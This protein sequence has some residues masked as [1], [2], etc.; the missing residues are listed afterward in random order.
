VEGEKRASPTVWQTNLSSIYFWQNKKKLAFNSLANYLGKNKNLAKLTSPCEKIRALIR[1]G[2]SVAKPGGKVKKIK[3]REFLIQVFKR[4]K[5]INI[6]C[7]SLRVP[8][9]T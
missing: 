7:L 8:D 3:N 6:I 2:I 1:V 4:W 5:S 9:V